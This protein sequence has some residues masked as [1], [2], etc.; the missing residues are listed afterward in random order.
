MPKGKVSPEEKVTPGQEK[1]EEIF[2]LSGVVSS[3]DAAN[4][5]LMVKPAG[6]ENNVKV[7]VSETTKLIKLELPFNPANPPAEA[8]FTPKQTEITISGFKAGDNVF[9][10]TAENIA[11][12]TTFDNVDFIHILP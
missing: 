5:F 3:V 9:V 7:I 2:S 10:K 12:K 6:K 1:V 4:N 8:T 11:G